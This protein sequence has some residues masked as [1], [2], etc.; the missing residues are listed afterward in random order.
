MLLAIRLLEED[1]RVRSHRITEVSERLAAKRREERKMIDALRRE[2][3]DKD[4]ALAVQK[5]LYL[6]LRQGLSGE[7]G[8][9]KR[10]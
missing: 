9:E 8:V 1:H 10:E 2:V 7:P 3:M 4:K 5:A 6:E